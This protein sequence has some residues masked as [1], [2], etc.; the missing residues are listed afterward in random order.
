MHGGEGRGPRGGMK[1]G[2]QEAPR[3]ANKG[4]PGESAALDEIKISWPGVAV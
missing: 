3:N 4:G 2:R 1:G